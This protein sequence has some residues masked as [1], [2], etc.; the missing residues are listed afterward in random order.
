MSFANKHSIYSGL[1][2]LARSAPPFLIRLPGE[3]QIGG[4][5]TDF[6]NITGLC[7]LVCSTG[8]FPTGKKIPQINHQ[9]HRL[10][11]CVCLGM[12]WSCPTLCHHVEYRPPDSSGHGIFQVRILE[13]VAVSYSRGIFLT[14]GWNPPMSPVPPA[15]AGGFPLPHLG[16]P[17]FS[18]ADGKRDVD[19]SILSLDK[20]NTP[21]FWFQFYPFSSLLCDAPLVWPTACERQQGT[22][23]SQTQTDKGVHPSETA[24]V[25]GLTGW[26]LEIKQ[27]TAFP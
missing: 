2:G 12:Y 9:K 26:P 15:L 11:G 20:G 18:G 8:N 5:Q 4:L 10:Q 23:S 6:L 1:W 7:N 19:L 25:K 14:Q 17:M 16:S 13:W 24:E 22:G 27:R 21:D 3:I